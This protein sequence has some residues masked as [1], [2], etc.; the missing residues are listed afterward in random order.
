MHNLGWNHKINLEKGIEK[1]YAWFL[2]NT[3]IIKEIKL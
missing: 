3:H 2:E 1:T